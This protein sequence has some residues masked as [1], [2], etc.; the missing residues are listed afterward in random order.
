MLLKNKKAFTLIELLIVIVVIG[1]LA[2]AMLPTILN[3]PDEARDAVN[4]VNINKINNS[5][6]NLIWEGGVLQEYTIAG[7]V[8]EA[9]SGTK[10]ESL[11]DNTFIRLTGAVTEAG[12]TYNYYVEVKEL[13]SGNF[14]LA[15]G[16]QNIVI[17]SVGVSTGEITTNTAGQ[18]RLN[19]NITPLD[20][21]VSKLYI[22][23]D[24]ESIEIPSFNID[25]I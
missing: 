3:G 22:W 8:T 25:N 15:I 20:G 16:D 13:N 23:K 6:R 7:D 17:D 19:R 21:I 14:Y 2:L 11:G 10:F 1:V 4:K 12:A 24:G 18:I 5:T 9:S